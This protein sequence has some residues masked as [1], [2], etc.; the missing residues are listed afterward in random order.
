[1]AKALQCGDI[2]PG[3][4]ATFQGDT[5]DDV[6]RQAGEHARTEH[7]MQQ[8]DA[9]TAEKVRG[10]ITTTA[11]DTDAHADLGTITN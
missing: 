2:M 3:C 7:G 1:M 8:I 4:T 5:E 11:P 10:A 6:M 9:Q